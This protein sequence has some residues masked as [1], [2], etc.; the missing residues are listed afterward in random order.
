MTNVADHPVP[1]DER[2]QFVLAAGDLGTWDWDL[3]TGRISWDE[4]TAAIFGTTLAEFDGTLDM[5]TERILLPED[6][7][8][9]QAAIDHAL[10]TR[11][12]F[13]RDYR[14][15][16]PD[17]AVRWVSARGRVLCDP[18][19]EPQAMVGVVQDRTE[20]HS[21]E[22]RLARTLEHIAEAFFSLDEDWRFTYLNARAEELLQCSRDEVLG[23]VVW[24]R[25][26]AAVDSAFEA[27]YRRA[28]AT[29]EPVTFE[30]AY[31][32]LGLWVE[33]RAYP[34][35]SGL[36]VYFHDITERKVEE[37]RRQARLASEERAHRAAA[38]VLDLAGRLAPVGRPEQVAAAV[39]TAGADI[40]DC[41]HVSVWR[42]S[43]AD[44][45]TLVAR[46]G[47]AAVLE[48]GATLTLEGL[49]V[50]PELHIARRPLFVADLQA[51][52]L[53]G[54]ALSRQL[55]V[56]SLV[57]VPVPL[58]RHGETQLTVLGWDR[59]VDAPERTMLDVAQQFGQQVALSIAQ[60]LRR[61]A[62]TQAAELN[63][64]LQASLLPTPAVTDGD[65][66]IASLY[67]PGE[68]RLKLG[69]DFFDV[70]QT[71]AGGFAMVVGDV[72]GHGPDA[73]ALGVTLRA[74]WRGL[75]LDGGSPHDAVRVLDELLRSERDS[76]EQLVTVCSARLDPAR[77]TLDVV[78]AGHPAPILSTIERTGVVA[79]PPG[80]LLGAPVRSE[81][82]SVTVAL[83]P[84]WALLFYTDGL[85]EARVAP[86]ATDRLG[87]RR[88]TDYVAAQ[89]PVDTP[90]AAA[91]LRQL[92]QAVRLAAGEPLDDDVALLFLRR[93][94]L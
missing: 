36:A 67:R 91:L 3:R 4:N 66:D 81:W 75:A 87:Q 54:R 14:V 24:E 10:A 35:P 62:E 25:F 11:G 20:T 73:A 32:P 40:F 74:A 41:T 37:Q 34:E 44:A 9:V 49:D 89:E 59:V 68:R 30:D 12:A 21:L 92:H 60:G 77:R 90:D 29:G 56:R 93:R 23:Q 72:T 58:G 53:A 7:E 86:Q 33:V 19:G 76:E 94:P 65:V 18:A 17:G 39:C 26:P 84:A 22:E 15:R 85:T 48:T 16:H 5:F 27:A 6:A 45:A 31:E 51:L 63:A 2:L 78:C 38:E 61:R 50:T 88:L 43:G 46:H 55:G 70:V 1:E 57:A 82:E 52:G 79:V 28:V 64:E 13:R 42:L 83:P 47:G 71:P 69:G 8:S 80:L